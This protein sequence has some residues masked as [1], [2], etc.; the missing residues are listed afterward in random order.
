M[1]SVNLPNTKIIAGLLVA[2]TLAMGGCAT[3][4]TRMDAAEVK[5]LSG[6]WNDTDSQQVQ[7]RAAEHL[8]FDQLQS[9]HMTFGSSVA[10]GQRDGGPHLGPVPQQ[11][12]GKCIHAIG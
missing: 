9:V 10:P 6:A 5:D 8:S 3:K 1:H 11:A 12:L 2:I 4:V 7:F